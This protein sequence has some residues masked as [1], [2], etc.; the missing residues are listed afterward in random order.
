[1]ITSPSNVEGTNDLMNSS[2]GSGTPPW[3]HHAG[4]TMAAR[5]WT[6]PSPRQLKDLRR[7]LASSQCFSFV[8]AALMNGWM[9]LGAHRGL[10]LNP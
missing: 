7:P 4:P 9:D 8:S 6:K 1:M 3:L 2:R 5:A 10:Y